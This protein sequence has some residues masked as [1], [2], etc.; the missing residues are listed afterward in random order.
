[1][2]HP[3]YIY[4]YKN[5]VSVQ[6]AVIGSCFLWVMHCRENVCS[7]QNQYWVQ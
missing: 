6:L 2:P 5:N 4:I 1:M 7:L 3:V